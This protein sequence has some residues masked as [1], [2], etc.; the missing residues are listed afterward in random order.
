MLKYSVSA[1]LVLAFVFVQQNEA[2]AKLF[3]NRVSHKQTNC[4]PSHKQT[5]YQQTNY[6]GGSIAQNKSNTQAAQGRMRHVGGSMG[7]GHYEGVGFS[8][9]SADEAI[10]NCCYWGQKTP[11]DIATARGANGWY[12][13]V[14][15]R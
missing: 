15:Y 14:I 6:Q 12:A 2:Q 10:R 13:T 4:Q 11:I 8:S 7:S 9:R 5:N 1:V 3:G